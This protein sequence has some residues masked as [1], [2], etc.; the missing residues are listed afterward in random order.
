[1]LVVGEA[2][3]SEEKKQVCGGPVAETLDIQ[4]GSETLTVSHIAEKSLASQS[5][6]SGLD[7][8]ILF[9][10]LFPKIREVSIQVLT[11]VLFNGKV[12]SK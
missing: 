3:V 5:P 4:S 1:M 11:S 9:T 12:I 8:K 7:F 10:P 2:F 6:L